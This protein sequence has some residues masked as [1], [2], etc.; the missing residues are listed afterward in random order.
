MVV[1]K[2]SYDELMDK[3]V[4]L[5][6]QYYHKELIIENILNFLLKSSLSIEEMEEVY[7]ILERDKEYGN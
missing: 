6:E 1:Y 5:E 4:E 3:I 7:K 2:M